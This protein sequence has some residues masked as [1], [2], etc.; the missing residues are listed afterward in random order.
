M[1]R[2]LVVVCVDG[3]QYEYITAAVAAGVAPFLGRLLAGSGSASS[4]IA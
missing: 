3:C 1:D 2:P 4:P